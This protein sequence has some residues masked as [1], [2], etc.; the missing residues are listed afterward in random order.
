MHPRKVESMS[1]SDRQ[2]AIRSVAATDSGDPDATP[3]NEFVSLFLADQRRIHRYIVMLLS[4]QQ[5]ADDLLQET[6]AVLWRKFKEFERGTSFFSWASRTAY[7]LVLE[8][9][10]RK[11]REVAPLDEDVLELFVQLSSGDDSVLEV[12]MAALEQC[13]S[14]LTPNDRHLIERS[15][16]GQLSGRELAL[17]LKRPEKSI[18]RSLGRVRRTLIECVRRLLAASERG[19]AL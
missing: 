3:N 9:R 6:A 10:R 18:Y 1:E 14:K 11:Q 16:S 8:Y 4:S 13:L 5:D 19:E 12:R 17:E 2:D 7:L 15:Y